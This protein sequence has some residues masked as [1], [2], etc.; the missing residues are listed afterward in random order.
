MHLAETWVTHN[1]LGCKTTEKPSRRALTLHSV[2]FVSGAR[3]AIL[4]LPACTNA[5]AFPLSGCMKLQRWHDTVTSAKPEAQ[6]QK[7]VRLGINKAP[8]CMPEHTYSIQYACLPVANRFM[9][10]SLLPVDA[11]HGRCQV[12]QYVAKVIHQE[13][14]S[15]YIELSQKILCLQAPILKGSMRSVSGQELTFLW[16]CL[17][18]NSTYHEIFPSSYN[19]KLTGFY[20]IFQCASLLPV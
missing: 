6:W 7:L 4:P 15:W 5:L 16:I 17:S 14:R 11:R 19:F 13:Y 10:G 3:E 8:N 18:G 2:D 20:Y 9:Q 12:A 1:Q